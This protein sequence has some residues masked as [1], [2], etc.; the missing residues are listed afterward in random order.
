MEYMDYSHEGNIA[1]LPS[2]LPAPLYLISLVSLALVASQQLRS[3][4]APAGMATG[5]F[6]PGGP[7][8][9]PSSYGFRRTL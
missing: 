7:I 8:L 5:R 2:L 4:E 6:V 9:R 1:P 3:E